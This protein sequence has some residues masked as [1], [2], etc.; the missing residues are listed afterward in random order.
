MIIVIGKKDLEQ[1]ISIFKAIKQPVKVL[2]KI[3][4]SQKKVTF[5]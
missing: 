5:Y 4:N 1:T 3:T 2:G